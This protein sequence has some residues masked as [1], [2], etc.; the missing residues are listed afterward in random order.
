M[1]G[2]VAR[3]ALRD[4]EMNKGEIHDTKLYISHD[5]PHQG[6]NVPL[7]AQALVRHLVGTDISLPFFFSLFDANIVNLGDQ[8]PALQDA[9]AL[10]ES[11][12]AQQMLI[13]QLQG[14][15]G[16]VS[17][18]GSTPHDSFLTEYQNMGYPSQNGI[19][20][21][22]IANGTDCGSPLDFNPYD[23]L[24]DANIKVDL[25]ALL[26]NVPFA[27]I[28]SISLNPLKTLSSLLSTNTDLK[29][30]FSLRALPSQQSLEIYKG[31]LFIK[32]KILFLINVEEPLID[33][34]RLNSGSNMLA[35]DNANGGIFDISTFAQLPP[36]LDDYVFQDRFNFVPAYSSLDV[37]MGATVITP[38]DLL[39]VYDATMPPAAPK[40]VP[41]D[42]FF[43]N[44]IQSEKHIQFTLNNGNWLVNEL[45]GTPDITTCVFACDISTTQIQGPDDVCTT[46]TFSLP[47]G[48]DTYTWT[49]TST[50]V[51]ITS[52][53]NQATVTRL[54]GYNGSIILRATI[55]APGCGVVDQPV[56]REI[57]VGDA[58]VNRW[59]QVD[60]LETGLSD[61]I[62][63][64]SCEDIALRLDI[65]PGN[66]LAIEWE[67]VTTNFT[68]S[69]QGT[70][71]AILAPFSDGYIELRVR[72]LNNCGWSRWYYYG[73]NINGCD[74]GGGFV[75]RAYPNPTS[76][77]MTIEATGQRESSQKSVLKSSVE[78]GTIDVL[79]LYDFNGRMVFERK[80]WTTGNLDLSTLK[81]GTYVMEITVGDTIETQQIII[82]K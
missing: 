9:L 73:L 18:N 63:S 52:A 74:S 31:K 16:N 39:K 59:D 50:D 78:R 8:V 38:Q 34:L 13:Y 67:R 53:G 1:G 60:K 10:V 58:V 3:Y 57:W 71:Y 30:E 55:D 14:T 2:L 42:N 4:M 69:Q 22:A 12:A 68:I 54:N 23:P 64:G 43:T 24:I 32:K 27:V 45:A 46:A 82:D 25:Y 66:P 21:I 79:R 11:P 29:A 62:S 56:V 61:P 72:L 7:A 77:N 37:G 41:F 36:E 5:S 47:G 33:E 35:L 28:N 75:F 51:N 19:R 81:N 15:G 17:I 80:Q 26:T 70:K 76:G 65:S 49:S 6:A 40:N 48:A 20:N 44:P